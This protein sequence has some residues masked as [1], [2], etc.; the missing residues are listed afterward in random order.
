[1]ACGVFGKLPS[2]RD[3]IAVNAPRRFL[4]AWEN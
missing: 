2:K 3:F 4:T 1:M